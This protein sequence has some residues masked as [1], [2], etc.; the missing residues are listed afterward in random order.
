MCF[1]EN[2]S[3]KQNSLIKSFFAPFIILKKNP[4]GSK[5]GVQEVQNENDSRKLLVEAAW[6][7]GCCASSHH[8]LGHIRQWPGSRG[9][10][11]IHAL[12]ISVS[13]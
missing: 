1:S 6:L 3:L 4:L 12:Q 2:V 10:D 8:S 11:G 9:K 7:R 13:N 5:R